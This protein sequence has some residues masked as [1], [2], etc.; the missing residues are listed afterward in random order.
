MAKT[1]N[2]VGAWSWAK[3]KGPGLG[4]A[5]SRGWLSDSQV[6]SGEELPTSQDEF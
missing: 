6:G 3:K 5:F 4:S 1:R 2:Q